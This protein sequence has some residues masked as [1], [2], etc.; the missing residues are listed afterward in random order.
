L[1]AALPEG[2]EEGAD[3]IKVIAARGS[4]NFHW[5]EMSPLDRPAPPRD[6][7]RGINSDPLEDLLR[8]IAAEKPTTRNLN[9]AT[10]P[11]REWVT[12]QLEVRV[13]RS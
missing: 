3:V 11:S 10:Y 4:A 12:A 13:R 1:R 2:Y 6:L 7:T 9:P 5:L 8:A